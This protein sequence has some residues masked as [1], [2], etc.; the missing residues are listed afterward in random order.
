MNGAPLGR[1][2]LPQLIALMFGT[3]ALHH[4]QA[5]T[6]D[7]NDAL[8]SVEVRGIRET[9]KRNLAEKRDAL[10]VVDSVTAEDLGKFPDK[11]VAD[12]LQ[13]IPGISVDRTWGEGR[14]IFV[15]GTDKT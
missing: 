8:Q 1:K 9:L 6:A 4:V 2:K 15:R 7:G 14:D 3:L 10:N 11:N 13:R 5:Q 12:S